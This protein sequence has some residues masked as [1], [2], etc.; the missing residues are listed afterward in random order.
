MEDVAKWIGHRTLD[1]T[2]GTYW[3]VEG[4]DVAKQMNIP[5]LSEHSLV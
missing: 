1:I 2:F 5:W 3:D 4:H